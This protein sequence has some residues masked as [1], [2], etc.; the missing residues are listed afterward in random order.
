MCLDMPMG[1]YKCILYKVPYYSKA[2]AFYPIQGPLLRVFQ[3]QIILELGG[4]N[5]L[6]SKEI[7]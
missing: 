1:L 5:A 7:G 6:L 4:L 3:Q 2:G